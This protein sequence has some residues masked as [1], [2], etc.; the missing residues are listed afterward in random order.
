[1]R[2]ILMHSRVILVLMKLCLKIAITNSTIKLATIIM[3]VV[4]G[5]LGPALTELAFIVKVCKVS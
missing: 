5:R 1:M 2:K 3:S 4:E